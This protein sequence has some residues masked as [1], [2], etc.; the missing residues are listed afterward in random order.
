MREDLTVQKN[1][2][3]SY[4][5]WIRENEPGEQDLSLQREEARTLLYRPLISVIVP[6]YETD[7]DMLVRM[8]ESVRAQTYEDWELCIADG[9]SGKTYVREKLQE[10]AGR[11]KRIKVVFLKENKHIAGNSNEALS[12][13]EGQFIGFLD[14]DDELAPFALYEIV[15][16]LNADPSLDFIYSDEDKIDA[17]GRRGSP[18]FKP[19]WSPDLLLSVNYICHF[20]VIRHF[21]LKEIGGFRNGFDGAQDYDLFLRASTVTSKIAHIPKILYHWRDHEA[22]TATDVSRKEYADS[23]GVAAL[24]DFLGAANLQAEVMPGV[25]KTNYVVRYPVAG[26]PLVSIIIPFKDK[27]VLLRKCV[28]S[29]LEKTTYEDY[30]IILVSNASS[31]AETFEYLDALGRNPRIRVLTFDEEFNYS[32]INNFGVRY[33][34]GSFLLF[35][36]NDTEVIEPEWLTF[37]LEHAQRKE[38]GAVGCKLLFPDGTIQHAG[39]IVGITGFAGHVFAGLP[40]HAYTAFGSADFLRNCL[41]VTGACLMTRKEVFDEVGGFDESFIVCGSDV[42]ICLRIHQKGYRNIYVPYAVLY[43]HEAAS[44]G[45]CI[46]SVDFEFS[47]RSY[48]EFLPLRDPYY[49]PNLT[50][51][52]T[53]CSLKMQDEK[54]TV[55]KI[56]EEAVQWA[57]S[58]EG[59]AHEEKQSKSSEMIA[60]IEAFDYSIGDIESSRQLMAE[61]TRNRPAIKSINW[62]IPYFHHVYYGGIYTILRFAEYFSGKGI[63]SRFV[64]YDSPAILESDV[65]AKIQAGFPQMRDFEVFIRRRPDVNVI[66]YADISIATL[67]TSAYRLL[68]FRHTRGKFY[69]IQDYEPLFYPA[70]SSY[71]L[72]EATYRF[73]FHGIINS[74]GLYNFIADNYDIQADYFV[75]AVDHAV[76]FPSDKSFEE[77]ERKLKLFFYG[78]PQH[79]RNAFDLAIATAKKIKAHMGHRIEIVSAG[80]DWSPADFGVSG[81]IQNLGLISYHETA[82]LYRTCDFGLILMFTKHTSYLPLELMASGAIVI[83][84]HNQAHTWLLRDGANC[85]VVEPSPTFITEKLVQLSENRELQ[86]TIRGNAL[87]TIESVHWEQE[88]EKIFRFI[89]GKI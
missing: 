9:N 1:A 45:S 63:R 59:T 38:I 37:L 15:R 66:P 23:A 79:D 44:R 87:K 46:P 47:L 33:A 51:L 31:E 72:A 88:M 48:R 22:S 21:L 13:A 57:R 11:D 81:I 41:A 32:R 2:S 17:H 53:D 36:N 25:V 49:N 58:C 18:F 34:R 61:F 5:T 71:A 68:Q 70:G 84:N 43:H 50:L 89:T 14:H 12:L 83:A 27:I 69:F 77:K 26:R 52:K 78:R 62:F 24:K 82:E 4:D 3:G 20:T 42:D 73:G 7:E 76:F 8:I 30:E 19:D 54:D 39:V 16:L 74:P 64:L 85:I 80:S 29:I 28:E 56:R 67:W 86:Q 60:M 10:Y 35:L 40:E 55:R 75:P 65:T 6:V